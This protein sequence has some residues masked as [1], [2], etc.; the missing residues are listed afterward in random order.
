MNIQ[1]PISVKFAKIDK[2]VI[3]FLFDAFDDYQVA[4]ERDD[5]EVS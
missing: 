5:D 4:E 1:V 3:V 2:V